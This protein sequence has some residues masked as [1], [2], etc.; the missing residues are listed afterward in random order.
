MSAMLSIE[1]SNDGGHG[2]IVCDWIVLPESGKIG[3]V[4]PIVVS[5]C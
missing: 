5:I 1:A 4:H 3:Y 2:I